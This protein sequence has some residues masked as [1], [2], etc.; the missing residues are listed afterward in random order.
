MINLLKSKLQSGELEFFYKKVFIIH[1]YIEAKD[2]STV[3]AN[4]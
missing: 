4:V 2:F 1:N 3:K